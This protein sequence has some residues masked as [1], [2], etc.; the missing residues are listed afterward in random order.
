MVAVL[1]ACGGAGG[2]ARPK[3]S[4]ALDFLLEPS[5]E[6]IDRETTAAEEVLEKACMRS[7]GLQFYPATQNPAE[8]PAT[9]DSLLEGG[10]S[11][12]RAP[13]KASAL[14]AAKTS[15]FGIYALEAAQRASGAPVS[16][17]ARTAQT[18]YED[19]LSPAQAANYRLAFAGS[20]KAVGEIVVPGIS[21][22]GFTTGG[23]L[24]EAERKVY[25]S[26][27]LAEE[28]LDVPQDI[29]FAAAHLVDS[30]PA[31][32]AA[33]KR[34]AECFRDASS[35]SVPSPSD[36]VSTAL[37][38]DLRQGPTQALLALERKLAVP[39]VECQYKTGYVST[40]IALYKRY[41]MR[42]IGSEQGLLLNLAEADALAKRRATA[43][44]AAAGR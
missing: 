20:P 37:A 22:H 38:P 41:A 31:E 33:A 7:K 2:T 24:G 16:E 32:L 18:Q 44:L 9:G 23:C 5:R 15:A 1:P 27:K 29:F 10:G 21:R 3:A 6:T 36:V 25:G 35:Y 43:V 40:R 14:A 17:E 39:D 28:A 13:S 8:R 19:S 12:E 34:W 42:F 11:L 4:A 26:V 30:D